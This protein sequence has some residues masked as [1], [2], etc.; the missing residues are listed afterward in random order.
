MSKD[1]YSVIVAVKQN[2]LIKAAFLLAL[3]KVIPVFSALL[4]LIMTVD[5]LSEDGLYYKL[6]ALA[7][8]ISHLLT[9]WFFNVKN[10]KADPE[11]YQRQR[12]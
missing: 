9:D 2:R 3:P 7:L 11:F 10:L 5:V 12:N 8:A 6:I 1:R 4:V